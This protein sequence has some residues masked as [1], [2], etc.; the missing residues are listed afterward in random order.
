[1]YN[2]ALKTVG[3]IVDK[4][5][6]RRARDSF[7]SKQHRYNVSVLIAKEIKRQNRKLLN[8]STIVQLRKLLQSLRKK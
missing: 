3:K 5:K 1:M 7:G 8:S 2:A 4:N 6:I